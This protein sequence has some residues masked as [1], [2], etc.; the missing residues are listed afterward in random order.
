[1]LRIGE[2]IMT[3]TTKATAQRLGERRACDRRKA[4][5]PIAGADRRVTDRRSG[6]ERRA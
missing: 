6:S 2:T 1:M 5:L 3:S 4:A